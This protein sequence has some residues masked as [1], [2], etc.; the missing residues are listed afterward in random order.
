MTSW[1]MGYSAPGVSTGSSHARYARQLCSSFGWR[2]VA[3]FHRSTSINSSSLLTRS[4]QRWQKWIDPQPFQRATRE[5]KCTDPKDLEQWRVVQYHAIR[6]DQ[7]WR[8]ENVSGVS[9][10]QTCYI[11]RNFSASNHLVLVGAGNLL[12]NPGMIP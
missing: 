2:R 12:M 6:V 10:Q 8:S 5:S 3:S 1:R 7:P 4:L 9:S 11:L